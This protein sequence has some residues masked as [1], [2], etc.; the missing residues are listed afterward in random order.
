MQNCI[1]TLRKRPDD[2]DTVSRYLELL[3]QCVDRIKNTVQQLLKIG[4]NE[5]LVLHLGNVD[6]MIHECLELTCIERSDILIDTHL[7]VQK[8]VLVSMESLRQV[9]VNLAG[10]AVQAMGNSGGTITVTSRVEGESLVLEVEDTGPGIAPQHLSKIFEP[11]FTTKEVGEGTGLGLSVSYSL[12]ERMGGE[13]TAW[14]RPES[15]AIFT[16]VVPLG[17]EPASSEE[18]S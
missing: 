18:G 8:P 7:S 6:K 13:L 12:V 5:P 3:S 10:N 14:N 11:F 9:I 2:P 16:V 1:Q 15:G 4:R 17:N